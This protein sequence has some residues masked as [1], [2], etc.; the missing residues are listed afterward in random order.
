MVMIRN[1]DHQQGVCPVKYLQEVWTSSPG[2]QKYNISES[3]STDTPVTPLTPPFSSQDVDSTYMDP[4]LRYFG[5]QCQ[6]GNLK[7]SGSVTGHT[8]HLNYKLSC[9]RKK[10]NSTLPKYSSK[11]LDYTH[12]TRDHLF[13]EGVAIPSP[14]G[15]D[16]NLTKI[17]RKINQKRSATYKTER[18][19]VDN[20]NCPQN[21]LGSLTPNSH[22][23]QSSNMNTNNAFAIDTHWT[24][25]TKEI[26]TSK[27]FI[28]PIFSC[29][30]FPFNLRRMYFFMDP[31]WLYETSW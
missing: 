1:G 2:I 10:C 26:Y 20:K 31:H 12:S 3:S 5:P 4:A 15:D 13:Q 17:A 29:S 6:Y 30:G 23:L 19:S 8:T 24:S 27:A 18:F 11:S 21:T 25:E 14:F 9:V 22:Y 16:T 7:N 28:K